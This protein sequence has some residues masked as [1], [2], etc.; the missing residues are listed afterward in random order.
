MRVLLADD[1]ELVRAGIRS[2]LV[3]L[4][5]VE[6][7]GEAGDGHRAL[8]L[9][10]QFR[11][12]IV[13]MDIMMPGLNG[14]E[15]TARIV[16]DFPQTKVVILSMN[17]TEEYV[18]QALRAG[19]TGYLLKNISPSELELAVNAVAKGETYLTA[20]VSKH[21]IENYVRRVGTQ[22]SSLDRLTPRQREVLQLIAEGH[23]TKEIAKR[24]TISVKTV[25]MHR[26]Q[27]MEALDI[28][29]IA[30]LVRY[31]IRMGIITP[32]A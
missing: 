29:E 5:G 21:V 19:A 28:H 2:L 10:H 13:L 23:R 27:I 3:N 25:E 24:L 8:E 26:T 16:K 11:P 15:A 20:A 6:V 14:L 18:L 1:H 17:A 4:S 12:D 31:A 7:V 30:G 32:E 9:V 22:T